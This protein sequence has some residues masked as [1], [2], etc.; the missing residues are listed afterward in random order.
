MN[1]VPWRKWNCTE[2]LTEDEGREAVA[3]LSRALFELSLPV[4]GSE[5]RQRLTMSALA[6]LESEWRV[7]QELLVSFGAEYRRLDHVN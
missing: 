1:P 4:P 3:G 5:I 6:S 2:N 7:E